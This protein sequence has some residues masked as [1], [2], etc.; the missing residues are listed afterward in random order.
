M[1]VAAEGNIVTGSPWPK[2]LLITSIVALFI[3][4]AAIY[5]GWDDFTEAMDPENNHAAEVEG[6]SSVQVNLTGGNTY[7]AYRVDSSAV[8]CTI[9]E[10]KTNTTVGRSSPGLLQGDRVGTD[11]QIYNSVGVYSPKESGLYGIENDAAE[12][13]TLWLVD[14]EGVGDDSSA[15]LLI[16]LGCLGFLF[17]LC[18][19]PIAAILW[20]T[21]KRKAQPAGLVMQTP[22]GVDI[23]IAAD[24]G[25]NQHRVPTTDEVWA[26]VHGGEALD[27]SVQQVAPEDEVPPPFASRPDDSGMMPRAVDDIEQIEDSIRPAAV[28]KPDPEPEAAETT[29]SDPDWKAWDEG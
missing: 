22:G 25:S 4:S 13:N 16:E 3:A 2:R 8:N 19:L 12:G 26:S 28:P 9:I 29:A 11:D 18:L 7:I 17:G 20:M 15:I 27:L 6:G 1:K 5:S 24:T 14:E 10:V 23:P 21:G